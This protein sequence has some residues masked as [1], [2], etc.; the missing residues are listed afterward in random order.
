M[1]VLALWV[2]VTT[3]IDKTLRMWNH[4]EWRSELVKEFG[5]DVRSVKAALVHATPAAGHASAQRYMTAWSQHAFIEQ[6]V[7]CSHNQSSPNVGPPATHPRPVASQRCRCSPQRCTRLASC[8]CSAAPHGC[9]CT[10][11][12]PTTSGALKGLCS[13]PRTVTDKSP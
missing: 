2:Q 6:P 8:C 11:C 13:L 9:A 1:R 10:P 7:R 5:E 4:A 3:G 12:S